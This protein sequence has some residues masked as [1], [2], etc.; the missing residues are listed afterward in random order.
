MIRRLST[1]PADRRPIYQAL[2]GLF[3]DFARDH[4]V[5]G[6]V[7][8]VVADGRSDY[9]KATGSRDI[10]AGD[11]VTPDTTFRIASMTKAITALAVLQLRDAGRLSLDA[12]VETLVPELKALP[13]PTSDSRRVSVR[14]LL[15]HTA[16]FIDDNAWAD[17]Q[18]DMTEDRFSSLL[19]AGP[20]FARPPGIAFEYSNLGY[21]ILGRAIANIVGR[22]YGEVVRERI[23]APLGMK[24]SGWEISAVPRARRAIPYAWIEGRWVEEEA[25]APG[26]FDAGGGLHTT[27]RDYARFV[28]WLLSAW[29]PRDGPD[30]P[31]LRRASLRE[32]V[33]GQGFPQLRP[34][35]DRSDPRAGDVAV[36]YGMGMVTA[37]DPDLGLALSHSG[38]LPGYRSNVLL[39]PHRG[40]G[41]FAFANLTDPPVATA[42]R[43]AML[44]LTRSGAFPAR[45]ASPCPELREAGAVIARIWAAGDIEAAGALAMNVVLDKSAARWK[46]ELASLRQALGAFTADGALEAHSAMAGTF[47]YE[48]ERG[49]LAVQVLLSP[50]AR[51]TIQKLEFSVAPAEN[52]L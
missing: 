47:T 35:A 42:V 32:I 40:L 43:E 3:A 10:E 22:P 37:A 51:P 19:A 27:A 45:P 48:C 12:P 34:R 14:D 2:G 17:R 6:L 4:H 11:A 41:L 24:A 36:S 16:G 28:A 38:G 23:L 49:R 21:A 33:Q 39:L 13:Y 8:G 5:P 25:L 26:A 20:P 30:D 7:F 29:P 15:A 50:T 31:I 9:V 1:P 52:T 46:G 44:A 18:I